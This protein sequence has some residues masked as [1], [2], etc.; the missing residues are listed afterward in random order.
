MYLLY[1]CTNSTPTPL[2][3][4][5]LET[6][7]KCALLVPVTLPSSI[8]LSCLAFFRRVRCSLKSNTRDDLC[9]LARLRLRCPSFLSSL[10]T[11]HPS[12]PFRLSSSL[13]ADVTRI[14]HLRRPMPQKRTRSIPVSPRHA[15][16]G[17]LDTSPVGP[18]FGTTPVLDIILLDRAQFFPTWYALLSTLL[19]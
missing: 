14:A 17:A 4:S 2:Q 7:K 18:L 16:R 11:H 1:H 13:A 12:A 3:Y 15:R 9:Q 8:D 6:F 19:S 10:L 5:T